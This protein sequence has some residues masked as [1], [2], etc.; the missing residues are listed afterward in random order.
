MRGAL[1]AK[2]SALF[3]FLSLFLCV[4]GVLAFLQVL[5]VMGGSR[6]VQ[7]ETRGTGGYQVAVQVL[8]L[9][10][11]VV[12]VPPSD[13]LAGLRDTLPTAMARELGA[14]IVR[15]NAM[16]AAHARHATDL[17]ASARAFSPAEIRSLLEDIT[18]VNAVARRAGASYEEFLLFGVF[19]GG[20]RWQH[21]F[22]EELHRDFLSI[23]HGAE[24]FD[25]T[26]RVSAAGGGE[27][28]P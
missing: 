25:A 4:M 12:V 8:C 26:W 24:P 16:T 22:L 13:A 7:M 18:Q 10:D 14:V 27:R 20:S 28:G 17:R 6:T 21:L 19:P 23:A 3:P 5:L 2:S 15:R 11:G 1:R 9:P